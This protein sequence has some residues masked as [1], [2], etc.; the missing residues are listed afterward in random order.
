MILKVPFHNSFVN[1]LEYLLIWPRLYIFDDFDVSMALKCKRVWVMFC[2]ESNGTQYSFF[3][4]Y[5]SSLLIERGSKLASH[6]SLIFLFY[7]SRIKFFYEMKSWGCTAGQGWK[8][9]DEACLG[10]CAEPDSS[11][12][13]SRDWLS[14]LDTW[15]LREAAMGWMVVSC[16]N[17]S[18]FNP[19]LFQ[20]TLMCRFNYTIL[21]LTQNCGHINE[22]KAKEEN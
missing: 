7:R 9:A 4:S 5:S 2:G 3:R 19:R 13:E 22:D 20:I 12:Q 18:S 17:P 15:Q 16:F 21:L 11:V 1:H 14:L 6:W 10:C 8:V